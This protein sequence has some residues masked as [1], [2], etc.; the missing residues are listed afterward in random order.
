MELFDSKIVKVEEDCMRAVQDCNWVAGPS[1]WGTNHHHS[2]ISTPTM[3]LITPFAMVCTL[4]ILHVLHYQHHLVCMQAW[5]MLFCLKRLCRNSN[6][7]V[8]KCLPVTV[9]DANSIQ[10]LEHNLDS[11]RTEFMLH[12]YDLHKHN[13][14]YTLILPHCI[15]Q[16]EPHMNRT[17][18]TS[19][20]LFD[21]TKI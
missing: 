5:S 21:V 3:S 19:L 15:M 6:V 14:Y 13:L 9:N 10:T 1:P 2:V 7:N 11:C 18:V 17:L 16:N 20:K 8:R 4:A 12:S